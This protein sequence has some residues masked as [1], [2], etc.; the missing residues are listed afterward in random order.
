MDSTLL[1]LFKETKIDLTKAYLDPKAGTSNTDGVFDINPKDFLRF[2]KLDLKQDD[3]RGLINSLTNSK[4]AIDCQIDEV[5][6]KFGITQEN[7]KPAVENFLAHFELSNDIPIKLK[8]IQA[9]NFAPSLL[10]SKTR[11]L[12][13]RLEHLYQKPTE[14][15]VHEAF[16]VA[17]LFIRSVASKFKVQTDDFSITD[18]KNYNEK[19]KWVYKNAI[20]F[21]FNEKTKNFDLEKTIAS[22]SVEKISVTPIE[23]EYFGIVRL[24]NSI[25]DEFELDDSLK[26]VLN[27]LDT[28]CPM[29]KQASFSYEEKTYAQ[30]WYCQ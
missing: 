9:L 30:H 20:S 13:N 10:I 8:F 15:E 17:D 25:D 21:S 14:N 16:D 7:F 5:L 29:T 12:R 23:K 24:M 4:R 18:E 3:E 27:S 26:I 22:K 2:A 1:R 19:N 28:L 6:Y 11:T